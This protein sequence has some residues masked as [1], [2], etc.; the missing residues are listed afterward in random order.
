[1]TGEYIKGIIHLGSLFD[2]D[3][4]IGNHGSN[5]TNNNAL[6]NAY[7]SGGRSDGNKSD[8]C[9]NTEGKYRW[10][11][12]FDNIKEHPGKT[13]RCSRCCCCAKCIYCKRCCSDCRTGVKTK[14]SKP[15]QT[16][17]DQNIRNICRR[18]ILVLDMRLS[19][20]QNHRTC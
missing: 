7:K 8:N 17:S 11:L 13:C 14:P 18:D 10:L 5:Q 15:E 2:R 16:G 12:S 3:G 4:Y 6:W 1:M 20:F 9:T 19:S